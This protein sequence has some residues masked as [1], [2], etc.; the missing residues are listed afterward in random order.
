LG[1]VSDFGQFYE[2]GRASDL[3][4]LLSKAAP[5]IS[6]LALRT[7]FLMLEYFFRFYL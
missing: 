1:I 3:K 5:F 7:S 4:I 6:D 2:I